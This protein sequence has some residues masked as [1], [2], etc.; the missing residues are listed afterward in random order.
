MQLLTN[1][2]V[3]AS[4]HGDGH[5]GWGGDHWWIWRLGMFL[6]WIVLIG[7]AFWWFRRCGRGWGGQH[8]ISG[9]ERARG[10][11]AER[12]ARGEINAEEYNERLGQLR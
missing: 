12:F 9:V 7:L 2:A 1:A 8:E 6:I 4:L 11:L 10:I 5:D 3:Y